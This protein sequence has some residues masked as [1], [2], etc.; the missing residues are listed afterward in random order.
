[1]IV[2][3]GKPSCFPSI[4][5]GEIILIIIKGFFENKEH[6]TRENSRRQNEFSSAMDEV[7]KTI[8]KDRA[9]MARKYGERY[10]S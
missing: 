4:G 2:S 5:I 10:F 1:M 6:A 3:N 9:D 8:G 7:E